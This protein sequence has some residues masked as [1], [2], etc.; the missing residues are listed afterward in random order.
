MG[1]RPQPG[2]GVYLMLLYE[3]GPDVIERRAPHRE[4]HLRLLRLLKEAG[5]VLMAGALGDPPT[6]AAL[7]FRTE[8]PADVEAFVAADPYV[9]N[10]LVTDWRILPWRVAV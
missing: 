6:G 3:Y 1:D 8:D 5:K 10:G 4:E 2:P 7:V 9:V